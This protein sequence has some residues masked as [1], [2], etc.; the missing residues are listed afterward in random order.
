MEFL[1]L[2]A[3]MKCMGDLG[4]EQVLCKPLAE[5]DN[6]KQQVYL[7]PGFSALNLLPHGSV[8]ADAQPKEPNFK[9]AIDLHWIDAEGN[10]Q[11]APGSQL[12]LYPNYPEVRLSGF[13]RGC[14]LA[15]NEAMRHVRKEQR[16]FNN[17]PDGR[18]L[19]FGIRPDGS[20]LTYLALPFSPV[21]N[22]FQLRAASGAYK[23][24]GV[25]Y[26]LPTHPADD[27]KR[28]LIDRL[29][30]LHRAEWLGGVR[31]NRHGVAMPYNARNGGGYTLEAQF[32]IV[33]NGQAEPDYRGWELKAFSGNRITLMTPEPDGGY[34]GANGVEAFLRQYG[35]Q[36]NPDTL[37]FTGIHRI[38]RKCPGSSLTLVLRGFDTTSGKI[39]D[40]SG[41]IE[42]IDSAGTATAAWSF[43]ALMSHWGRKHAFAAYVPFMK[44]ETPDGGR[45]YWYQSPALF[46]EGTDFAMCLAAMNAGNVV[47]DPG[48]KLTGLT[49]QRTRVKA[50]SQFRV[51]KNALPSLYSQFYPVPL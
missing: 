21:A 45:E 11:K 43:E 26:E 3:L 44:R 17:G 6:S 8:T 38:G 42:L 1:S 39:T 34:Y 12:I 13:L 15:P 29:R 20:V 10:A 2:D 7:G 31:L 37:Y 19:F 14:R 24:T 47:Y 35:R 27:A 16:R 33:P 40:V 36:I 22:E 41:G 28:E 23:R 25:F 49:G 9:A 32:Q 46:G 51:A 48:S 18:L 4:A 30:E 50:R 5:N